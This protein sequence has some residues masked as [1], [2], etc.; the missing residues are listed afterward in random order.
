MGSSSEKSKRWQEICSILDHVA[1]LQSD[2]QAAY[3]DEVCADDVELHAEIDSYLNVEDAFPEALLNAVDQDFPLLYEAFNDHLSRLE[4]EDVIKKQPIPRFRLLEEIGRGGMGRVYLAERAGEQFVQRAAVKLIYR[5]RVSDLVLQRFQLERQIL[6][7]F[8]HPNIARFLDGDI[9]EDGDPY[10][11]MEYVEGEPITSYC[12]TRALPLKKRLEIFLKLCEAVQYSHQNLIIHRDL[13]PSNVLVSETGEV[14]LLDF[15][16]AKPLAEEE[17]HRGI[18]TPFASMTEPGTQPRTL[19]YASPE[20]VK[21]DTVTTA[22]DVYGLGVLLYELLT[23]G[24]PYPRHGTEKRREIEQIIIDKRPIKPSV[25]VNKSPGTDQKRLSHQLKGDLDAIVLK[26]IRKESEQRYRSAGAFMD[27]IKRYLE[28]HPIKAR[29]GTLGYLAQK[30][31][32]RHKVGVAAAA[33]VFLAIALGVAGIAWQSQV[34]AQERDVARTEANKATQVSI[35][36][37]DLFDFSDPF[38]FAPVQGDTM[39]VGEVLERGV[40]K[41]RATLEDQPLVLT[42]MLD[43]IGRAFTNLGRY[44]EAESLLRESLAIRREHLG[45]DHL[46]VVESLN[47]LGAFL[48]EI[49]EYDE[50]DSVLRETLVLR[51]HFLGEEHVKVAQT[52]NILAG[53]LEL[54]GAAYHDD[55]DSLYRVSLSIRRRLLGNN[56][57]DV[58]ESIGN[59]GNFLREIGQLEEAEPLLRETLTLLLELTREDNLNTAGV[60]NNLAL[61]LRQKALGLSDQEAVPVL[62]EAERLMRDVL[63]VSR[64]QLGEESYIIPLAMNSLAAIRQ[65]QGFLQSDQAACDEAGDL[66]RQALDVLVTHKLG[67]HPIAVVVRSNLANL[68]GET[69]LSSHTPQSYDEAASLLRETLALAPNIWDAQHAR[70]AAFRFNLAGILKRKGA[71]EEA[72]NFYNEALVV[73]ESQEH[74]ITNDVQMGLGALLLD[75]GDLEQAEPLLRAALAFREASLDST[76]WKVAEAKNILAALLMDKSETAQAEQLLLESF[77]MIDQQNRNYYARRV[78]WQ[79]LNRL[80]HFYETEGEAAKATTYRQIRSEQFQDAPFPN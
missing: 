17:S 50:A 42:Q 48:Y 36:L 10:Y 77:S 23:D 38:S 20:Q 16:I 31:I 44:E 33:L 63:A 58:A 80:I 70:I 65:E 79:T 35:F 66:Y 19:R 5:E 43:A 68:L 46:D 29:K 76:H 13:K 39:R 54:K 71:Y 60:R 12:N 45:T 41:A 52:M 53:V 21:G 74:P 2:A 34:A 27:D 57:V 18:T 72:K 69:C 14:K 67:G 25:I 28:G 3:L 22:T 9:T 62:R 47:T 1:S 78:K 51:K 26:A 40:E 32:N 55:A 4:E 75:Q 37:V 73:L 7:N 6:A 59:Y 56:H 24:W 64:K 49:G 15:G 61:L 30:F 8:Q 11:V